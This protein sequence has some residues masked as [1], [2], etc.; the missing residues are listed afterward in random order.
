MVRLC[1]EKGRRVYR[2]KAIGDKSAVE[3]DKR[4]AKKKI[5]GPVKKTRES[6]EQDKSLR[7]FSISRRLETFV[8]KRSVHFCLSQAFQNKT[9]DCSFR[10][11]CNVA[12]RSSH[13]QILGI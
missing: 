12:R 9:S 10:F 7:F 4:K 13:S 11:I 5:H 2:K 8:S 6:Q 1:D 3:E